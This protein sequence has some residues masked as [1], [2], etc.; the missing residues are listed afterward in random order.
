MTEHSTTPLAA[1]DTPGKPASS[2][3]G[4][5]LHPVILPTIWNL[6]TPLWACLC[7]LLCWLLK[8]HCH[9]SPHQYR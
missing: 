1:S 7:I 3:A 9:I 8:T 6:F 2:H 4:Q 5:I